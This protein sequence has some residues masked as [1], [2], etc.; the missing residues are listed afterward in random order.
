MSSRAGLGALGRE[1]SGRSS[2]RASPIPGSSQ[3]GLPALPSL[4]SYSK[5][6]VAAA[7]ESGM[8]QLDDEW[9]QV[10]VRVLPLLC[11]GDLFLSLN[12]VS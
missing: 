5:K 3:L 12:T 7:L 4:E 2:Y 1:K 8:E 11:V 10:V 9:Q 6:N